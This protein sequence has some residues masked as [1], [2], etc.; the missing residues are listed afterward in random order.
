MDKDVMIG[1]PVYA[2]NL[3]PETMKEVLFAQQDSTCCVGEIALVQGDSLVTRARNKIVKKFL[4][5]DKDYLMFIDSDIIFSRNHLNK[6]RAKCKDIIG[7]VYLKKMLPYS[8]VSNGHLETL[9]DGL[10]IMRE[11]GTGFMM[12]HRRVFERLIAEYPNIE[13]RP[14]DDE[15]KG[16]YYDFFGVGKWDGEKANSGGRYLS[17][18]YY[19]CAMAREVGYKIHY[20]PSIL[21]G[22][23]GHAV[24]PFS[25]EAIFKTV[26]D[27][28][29]QWNPQRPYPMEYIEQL[30]E[31]VDA[32]PR[33]DVST[34]DNIDTKT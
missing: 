10:M 13:Y 15:D 6:L 26:I 12:I 30:K 2:G 23:A 29:R 20:D 14:D 19:F 11:I 31:L 9:D 3:Q 5:S 33:K 32:V 27:L 16:K 18:D 4:E 28:L 25:D 21:V 17:E 8:P 1:F 24:F 34:A 22:H 7:G